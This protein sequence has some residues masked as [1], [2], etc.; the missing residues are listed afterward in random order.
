MA[1]FQ[2]LMDAAVNAD[3]AGDP[4]AARMLVEMAESTRGSRPQANEVFDGLLQAGPDAPLT[5]TA[6]APSSGTIADQVDS[7][8]PTIR[9]ATK[10]PLS[11]TR[12]FARGV[13]DQSQSPTMAALPENMPNA[14]KEPVA[15]VGDT[16]GTAGSALGT[17]F[18]FGAGLVGEIAGGSP[19]R[20]RQLARDLMMA[21]QVAIPELAGVS[22]AAL[23]AQSGAR[24]SRQLSGAVTETQSGARAADE[25]GITPSLGAGGKA[26][27]MTAAAL[28]KIPGAGS[29]I[30]RD[31]TRFVGEVEDAF[32]RTVA[33]IG[34]PRNA[35]GAGDALQSGLNRFVKNFKSKSEKLFNR[36]GDYIPAS[37][38]I[39]ASE[40]ANVIRESISLFENT[41]EIAQQL[42]LSRWA[43]IADELEG[44]NLT[45]SA[46]KD[47]RSSIGAN[48]GSL[49]GALTDQSDA[50]LK[51]IYAS[52]T[53][54]ME[55]AAK[56]AGPE[57]FSAWKRANKH[58]AR[59][60]RQIER[61]LDKTI[62]AQSPERAFEAFVNM[63]RKDRASADAQRMFSIK[64]AMPA[65]EWR[66]V[67]ASIVDRLGR[68]S[69]GRQ[70]A[71]GNSFSPAT[72]LTEWNK[73]SDEAKS[74]LFPG[75]VRKEI[76]NLA[77]VADLAKAANAERNMSNTATAVTGAGIG[78]GFISA[79]VTTMSFL[80][81][82]YLSAKAF[83]SP[84]LL[85]AM[86]RMARGDTRQM[87]ALA[88]G[89]NDIAQDARTILRITAAE[90]AATDNAANAASE[91][92]I[93]AIP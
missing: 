53:K 43:K 45:W 49:K 36:V 7:F 27:G 51:R 25:L 22:S 35:Q 2:E 74:V 12:T 54:D 69:A 15:R 72:F 40:T 85:R 11:A 82:S 44:G 46:V 38:N 59:G 89:T 83:T 23:A 71:D 68:P 17:A 13:V 88:K 47:Y 66:E 16:L 21:G 19:T 55:A 78:A 90:S 60:A 84:P 75:G 4:E 58:Y 50:Q 26:R 30:S 61:D 29:V 56:S 52:L 6:D 70:S 48:I 9:A 76:S 33:S 39:Q 32:N 24:A 8:G 63:M 10:G 73:L 81:G 80:G 28:E 37:T 91:P 62:S 57:A 77:K 5:P 18:G 34:T 42:G 1:T 79:P 86:N 41:P 3:N 92:A 65:N 64:S 14:L 31:A 67:S 87:R 93:R 20:E